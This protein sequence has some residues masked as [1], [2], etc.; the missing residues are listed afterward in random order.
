MAN[1]VTDSAG[2]P[3]PQYLSEDGTRYEY[4]Q[5]KNGAMNVNI[6]GLD[7]KL[8]TSSTVDKVLP[9]QI[10]DA[11]G[12]IVTDFV[13]APSK[14]SEVIFALSSRNGEITSNTIT[15]QLSSDVSILIYKSAG[16][17][18]ISNVT[19]E[20]YFDTVWLPLAART[21]SNTEEG[22]VDIITLGVHAA[23]NPIVLPG[24]IRVKVSTSADTTYAVY[25]VHSC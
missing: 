6:K 2:R 11:A 16:S 15:T 9:T 19:I 24:Q 14:K 25:I 17:A 21:E 10:V 5:G 13:Y 20:G 18:P 23:G 7:A 22:S 1:L 4:Q 3:A 12:N 8:A